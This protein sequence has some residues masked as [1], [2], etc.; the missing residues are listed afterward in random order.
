LA[1]IRFA[2]VVRAWFWFLVAGTIAGVVLSLAFTLLSPPAYAGKVSLL[3]TPQPT[4]SGTINFGDI[5]TTQALA[6][7]FAELATTTP[8]LQRVIATTG[9]DV[10]VDRLAQEIS[11]R[12]PAGTSLVEVTVTNPSPETA[13]KLA[14]AIAA[15]LANYP[16]TGLGSQPNALKVALVVVDPAS[17]AAQPTGP[18]ILVRAALGG[19]IALFLCIAFAMLIENLR[20]VRTTEEPTPTP[21]SPA[22]P[23]DPPDNRM[24]TTQQRGWVAPEPPPAPPVMAA[25][26][27]LT[28]GY[29]GASR[30]PM[31]VPAQ[32][33]GG[34]GPSSTSGPGPSIGSAVYPAGSTMSTPSSSSPAS[35]PA[36]G[37]PEPLPS[38][39]T[40]TTIPWPSASAVAA[41]T[42]VPAARV[43]APPAGESAHVTSGPPRL[44]N[45][46]A[47]PAGTAPP[48]TAAT[49]S[50]GPSANVAAAEAAATA[51]PEALK[52]GSSDAPTGAT[53]KAP[54]KPSRKSSRRR[55]P[56]PA[57]GT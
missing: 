1:P 33:G 56:D 35:G 51:S 13:A 42:V 25:S 14:N 30:P 40:R 20:Q 28:S 12:V 2:E 23:T 44:T 36:G 41:P 45:S 47:T 4:A 37:D 27:G 53:S 54:A 17:P 26:A 34:P 19:A 52:P 31:A 46:P 3:V 43:S 18:G 21:P 38:W 55:A 8:V 10:T 22:W 9:V 6:P 29:A 7:T 16:G 11:T 15:E 24:P 50:P 5:Q 32:P 39:A 48:A 57:P 49:A